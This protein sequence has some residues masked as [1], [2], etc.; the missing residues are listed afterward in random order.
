V[1]T[2]YYC[3]DGTGCGWDVWVRHQDRYCTGASALCDGN[4]NWDMQVVYDDCAPEERCVPGNPTCVYDAGCVDPC[5]TETCGNGNCLPECGEI[6]ENCP[7]DCCPCETGPCCDGCRYQPA[8][9]KCEEDVTTEYYCADGTG[10]G[11]DVWVRHQD[12]Y[13]TGASAGC[14]GNLNWDMQVV[15]DDCAPTERCIPGDPSC[16]PDSNCP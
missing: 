7:E 13:C 8:T 16:N 4:T 5:A 9:Y 3:A 15:Y 6:A 12:R 1:T 11:Y 2:E 14:D 10:C